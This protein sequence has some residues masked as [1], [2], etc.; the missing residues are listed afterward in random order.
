MEINMR[1]ENKNRKALKNK[2]ILIL[3]IADKPE[4]EIYQDKF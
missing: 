3:R 4:K 1:I 2:K